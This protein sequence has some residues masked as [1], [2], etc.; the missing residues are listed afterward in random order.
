MKEITPEEVKSG[1]EAHKKK[2]T[3]ADFKG[4]PGYWK[5]YKPDGSY[6]WGYKYTPN[7][8][9]GKLTKE[10]QEVHEM[11]TP[12]NHAAVEHRAKV[13]SKAEKETLTDSNGRVRFIPAEKARQTAQ[14]NGWKYKWN[15]GRRR[16]RIG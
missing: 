3:E 15:P 8:G 9:H 7:D 11:M 6:E 16:T 10:A 4:K 12:F 14:R 5:K 1:A 2:P 13:E